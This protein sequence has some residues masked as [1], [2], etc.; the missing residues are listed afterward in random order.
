MLSQWIGS[1]S[2]Q[3]ENFLNRFIAIQAYEEFFDML[4]Q[5]IEFFVR[6]YPIVTLTDVYTEPSGIWDG[7]ETLLTDCYI[8]ENGSSV[9]F[10]IS[11]P[12]IN[13]KGMRVRYTGGMAYHAVNSEFILT[14]APTTPPTVGRYVKGLTSGAMGFTVSYT[15]GTLT[16]VIENYYGIFQAGEQLQE[17]SDEGT[18]AI[19]GVLATISSISKQSLAEAYPAIVLAVESQIRYMWKYGLD[20]EK[21]SISNNTVSVHKPGTFNNAPFLEEVYHALTPYRKLEI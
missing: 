11:I 12:W 5:R 10:P 18:T 3:V 6:G 13:K 7:R 4:Y 19:S 8:G 16:W 17:Y 9:C 1:V 20:F 21:T 15:A 14:G 2:Q